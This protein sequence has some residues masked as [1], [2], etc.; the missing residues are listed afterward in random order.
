MADQWYYAQEGQQQGP[1]SQEQLKELAS[2]GQLKPSNTVWKQGMAQWAKAGQV[3]GLFPASDPAQPPPTPST[4]PQNT[5]DVKR[6]RFSVNSFS[7]SAFF[8]GRP[9]AAAGLIL[10]LL[11]RGCDVLAKR[12]F[13]STVAQA[14]VAKAKFNDPWTRQTSEIKRKIAALE[15][16]E[17]P[18]PADTKEIQD[19]RKSLTDV[20]KAQAKRVATFEGTTLQDALNAATYAESDY[21]AGT[22]WREMLF[23]FGGIVLALGLLMVSR[24]AEGAERWVALT[25]LAIIT[26]SLFISNVSVGVSR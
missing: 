18:T 20:E 6:R 11:A 13:E 25:M 2:S 17:N 1:V 14:K 4:P 9:M 3:S 22:Y 23:L 7:P 21:L 8:A 12:G 16:K 19:A 10:V 15:E 26:A 24:V 5:S